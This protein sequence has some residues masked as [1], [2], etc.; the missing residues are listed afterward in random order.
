MIERSELPYSIHLVSHE[1]GFSDALDVTLTNTG[2]DD[3]ITTFSIFTTSPSSLKK[4]RS[5]LFAFATVTI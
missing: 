3:Q 2:S 1:Y 5:L 4:I